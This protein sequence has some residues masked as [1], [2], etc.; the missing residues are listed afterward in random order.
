MFDF[1]LVTNTI[2]SVTIMEKKSDIKLGRIYLTT[3]IN[4]TNGPPHIGHAY[5]AI[6]ADIMARYHDLVGRTVYFLT[7]TDEHGQKIA[8]TAES[9]GLTPKQLCD[10]N[11]QLFI[12][13]NGKLNIFYTKFIRTTDPFHQKIAQ[14]IFEKVNEKGDIYL[15]EYEGWY[16]QR[17]ERFV[18]A[19]EAASTN[20]QDPMTNKPYDL[21]KEPSYF[22]RMESYRK[23]L[24]N[25]IN[26]H[27][28]FIND[29]HRRM[30][31]L[32]RLEEPLQDLSISRT[33]FDWGIPLPDKFQKN[34][35]KHV[36]YVWFDALTNYLSGIIND[37]Q[38]TLECW[39][40]Y[41]PPIHIIGQDILWFHAV[42]WPCMLLSAG[43]S[44]PSSI[45]VHGFINDPTGKKMSKSLGNVIDPNDLLAKYKSDVLRY[46][47]IRAGHYGSDIRFSED[48]LK[49][50]N[51]GELAD[52]YGNLVSRVFALAKK[53]CQ[54]TVPDYVSD[55]PTINLDIIQQIDDLFLQGQL[56][57]AL[58]LIMQQVHAI[59][60]WLTEKAP[61]KASCEDFDKK[62][63]IRCALEKVYIITHL[64]S[65]FIPEACN[66]V[67]QHYQSGRLNLTKMS[68]YNLKSQ[69]Q[70]DCSPLI[71]FEK[72]KVNK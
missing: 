27:K 21:V 43:I 14:S 48:Q 5:E 11:A 67:L 51:D 19:T 53:Y 70:L 35:K 30:E 25:Y 49:D 62:R 23:Q 72:I 69:S 41:E 18:T 6:S 60:Q 15:G 31:I 52:C 2:I 8:K 13:L 71:L 7:G 22:F 38:N 50:K 10:Q 36:M 68:Q 59:N 44:L 29:E 9:M 58:D 42:I 45:I 47:F 61:W 1:T 34:E 54:S 16:N 66:S 24:V 65:P 3:A 20:Y 64:L 39:G 33:S 37:D 55:D 46:Y 40:S 17:E 12:D 56:S 4:Y 32:H 63:I 57:T 26:D 28:N